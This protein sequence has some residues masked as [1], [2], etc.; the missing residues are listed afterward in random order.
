[1]GQSQKKEATPELFDELV[2]TTA[3][4]SIEI[5]KLYEEFIKD[6][7]KGYADRDGFKNAYT[8]MFPQRLGANKFAGHIFRMYDVDGNG[9]MEFREYVSGLSV[10]MDGTVEEKLQSCFRLYDKDRSG[11]ITLKELTDILFVSTS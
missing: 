3:F 5:K 7:P 8:K 1:M 6:F 11:Y 2:H 9:R 4:S 10:S